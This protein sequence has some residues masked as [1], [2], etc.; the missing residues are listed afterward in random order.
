MFCYAGKKLT[1]LAPSV[2]LAIYTAPDRTKGWA[3]IVRLGKSD[4]YTYLFKPR[5]LDPT[6]QY[7]V[8]LDSSGDTTTVHGLEL[9]RDGLA[10]RLEALMSSE[11][12]LLVAQ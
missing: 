7:R 12:L 5:G 11:L 2:L 6:R 1:T 10:L 8:T 4:T 3:T 9:I